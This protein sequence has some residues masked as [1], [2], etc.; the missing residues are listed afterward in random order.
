[1]YNESTKLMMSCVGEFVD[2]LV[3]EQWNSENAEIVFC[4]FDI[5]RY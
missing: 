3:K 1:M 5:K 4:V 2:R